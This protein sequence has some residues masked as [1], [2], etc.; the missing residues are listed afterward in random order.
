MAAAMVAKL[1]DVVRIQYLPVH[2]RLLKAA[3]TRQLLTDTAICHTPAY[4]IL[5]TCPS[6]SIA[7]KKE[8]FCACF[9]NKRRREMSKFKE[10]V[11]KRYFKILIAV[12]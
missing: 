2:L 3:H 9:D 10:K 7:V 12:Q 4:F 5:F 8:R 11:L 1:G 6:K